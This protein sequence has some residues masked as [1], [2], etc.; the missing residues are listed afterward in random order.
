MVCHPQVI[1]DHQHFT[2][3]TWNFPFMPIIA[4]LR[5]CS[6]ALVFEMLGL[7][8]NTTALVVEYAGL[9]IES[10]I[11]SPKVLLLITFGLSMCL[12]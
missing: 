11:V 3:G 5:W 1:S 2:R 7:P 10:R 12:S 8:S 9:Y 4:R 6:N